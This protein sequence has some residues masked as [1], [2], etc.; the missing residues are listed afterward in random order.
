[1]ELESLITAVAILVVSLAEFT[2]IFTT[3]KHGFDF[4]DEGYYLNWFSYPY[5]YK[6]SA[7][8][9]GFLFHP[10]FQAVGSDVCVF[11]R[12]NALAIMLVALTF[13]ITLIRTT[14]SS[15]AYSP[16]LLFSLAAGMALSA[17]LQLQWLLL[18]PSYNWLNETGIL[19]FLIGALG[20]A[21]GVL[22]LPASIMWA[23]LVGA[24]IWLSGMAKPPTAIALAV[25]FVPFAFVV[26][27]RPLIIVA[28]AASTSVCLLLATAILIDSSLYGFVERL[29]LG[30]ELAELL[31][32]RYTL[33]H[34]FARL[35]PLFLSQQELLV[36]WILF[37]AIAIIA[38]LSLCKYTW[39]IWIRIGLVVLASLGTLL[40]ISRFAQ[41]EFQQSLM[42]GIWLAAAPAGVTA[43][44]L[45]FALRRFWYDWYD[46]RLK[47]DLACM[48]LL[49]LTPAV[50]A[51]GTG[52]N[53][54]FQSAHLLIS[55]VGAAFI[56]T[57]IGLS[58]CV[59]KPVL[60]TL[61][62][63]TAIVTAVLVTIGIDH[64][65]RSM[66]SLR[67]QTD[68]AVLGAGQGTFLK[69]SHES[70][71]YIRKI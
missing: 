41:F 34:V 37:G 33:N 7:S 44:A 45:P 4:T 56:L 18:T 71:E 3:A 53:Y 16:F 14:H 39:V 46:L 31:A 30:S 20:L 10:I 69:L 51:V 24:G 58:P 40:I 47:N 38:A 65:Y 29:R 66:V 48:F 5:L 6:E 19:I 70:A 43:V 25:L 26:S 8:Q 62:F 67:D 68:P 63:S 57:C 61:S 23:C 28:T 35:D 42:Q 13:S 60:C 50:Y 27:S 21:S 32:P 52:N 17:F 54:W 15:A 2:L 36:F 22:R 1:M 9:F 12:L 64:P 55:W 59:A 11:R 49:L